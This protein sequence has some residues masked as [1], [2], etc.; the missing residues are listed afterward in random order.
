MPTSRRQHQPAIQETV[1]LGCG[2]AAKY[3]D[4]GGNFSVPLQYAAGLKRCGR[5]FRW[6]ELLPSCG[7]P[8]ED[9]RRIRVF[10]RRMGYHGLKD[11]YVLLLNKGAEFE[12]SWEHLEVIGMSR[13]RLMEEVRLGLIL[14]LSY[15]IRPPILNAFSHRILINLDPTEIGYYMGQFELGQSHHHEFW[16]IALNIHGGDCRLPDS[17]IRWKTFYPP[18]DTSRIRQQ[19]APERF[20]FTTVGQW[21][22]HGHLEID[23]KASDY[24]KRSRFMPY[25]DLPR[26]V[27]GADFE[28]AMNMAP[29]DPETARIRSHGWRLVFPHTVANTPQKYLAYLTKAAAEFTPAKVDDLTRTGWLSDRAAV[30]LALG[31]PV[32]TVSTGAERYLPEESGFLF[33]SDLP[34]AVEACRRVVC[35]W[36][37]LSKD[38][39]RTA[40]DL[41]D[42]ERNL[43]R[44]LGS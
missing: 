9:A 39:R 24:S 13:T 14:N 44:I 18:V 17:G 41:F 12:P 33:V 2:F 8:A 34:S 16:T 10:V 25:M 28:M 30:F 23:G 11:N 15:S 29:E 31:R 4:G 6:F 37:H 20:K 22:W 42:A 35:D 43:L 3:P 38:A 27:P 1:F 40:V 7:D 36:R 21:Y 32:V 5:P 26:L 19:P